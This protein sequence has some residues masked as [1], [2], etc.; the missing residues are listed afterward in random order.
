MRQQVVNRYSRLVVK[1]PNN[2]C[3][4]VGCKDSNVMQIAAKIP[5]HPYEFPLCQ[6]YVQ[7]IQRCKAFTV[8]SWPKPLL[9]VFVGKTN[10]PCPQ[11]RKI[12]PP[13]SS[14]KILETKVCLRCGTQFAIE[15]NSVK[16]AAQGLQERSRVTAQLAYAARPALRKTG[17]AERRHP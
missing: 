14:E 9:A 3:Q 4:P 15:K 7:A 17:H 16:N 10:E 8:D 6:D 11:Y 1:K 12:S 5:F 2:I 13:P